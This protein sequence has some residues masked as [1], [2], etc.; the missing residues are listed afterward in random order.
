MCVLLRM[1]IAFSKQHPSDVFKINLQG[2]RMQLGC[3]NACLACTKPWT[4][5]LAQ[6]KL[7]VVVHTVV[8]PLGSTDKRIINSRPFQ[9]LVSLKPSWAA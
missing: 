3:G 4:Q 6:R 8:R 9:L 1:L 7:G 2:L 5:S